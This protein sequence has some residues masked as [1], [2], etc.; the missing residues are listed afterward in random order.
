MLRPEELDPHRVR[1]DTQDQT[2]G[3]A[4]PGEEGRCHTLCLPRT[5][6]RAGD[7]CHCATHRGEQ[8]DLLADEELRGYQPAQ[9][10]AVADGPAGLGQPGH[11][12]DDERHQE[13]GGGDGS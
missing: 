6:Q 2:G 11:P 8:Q 12:P 1:D 4:E 3:D 5:R 7:R 9:R 10:E 13:L